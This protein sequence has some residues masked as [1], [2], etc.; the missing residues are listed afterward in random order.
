MA[1]NSAAP[2]ALSVEY[3][4]SE[5][6]RSS[7]MPARVLPGN[8]PSKRLLGDGN[9]R[10]HE[11]RR[12]EHLGINSRNAL[13][14]PDCPISLRIRWLLDSGSVPNSD[15]PI[16]I[17]DEDGRHARLTNEPFAALG[18]ENHS[19][20]AAHKIECRH[21]ECLGAHGIGERLGQGTPDS[22][23]GKAAGTEVGPEQLD[24]TQVYLGLR[25]AP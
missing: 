5:T 2:P 17:R 25:K 14:E 15:N 23:S 22:H 1:N 7:G 18:R 13:K 21:S 20:V 11:V 16:D 8:L 19:G 6:P 24:V 4:R 9:T 10:R 12:H 3:G